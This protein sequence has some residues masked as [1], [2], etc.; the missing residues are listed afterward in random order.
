M[1]NTYSVLSC[2]KITRNKANPQNVVDIYD[3]TIWRVLIH[4]VH[5]VRIIQHYYNYSCKGLKRGLRIS[6]RV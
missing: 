5:D 2:D 4:G 6:H 3:V 1:H